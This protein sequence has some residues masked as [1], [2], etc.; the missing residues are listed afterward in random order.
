MSDQPLALVNADHQTALSRP[1]TDNPHWGLIGGVCIWLL[2]FSLPQVVPVPYL[3]IARS[4]GKVVIP[5]PDDLSTGNLDGRFI[6][7]S[8]VSTLIIHIIMLAACWAVVTHFG[9]LPF[10]ATLGWHWGGMPIWMRVLLVVGVMGTVIII[11]NFLPRVLPDTQITPFAHILKSSQI[12]KY[13]VAGVAVLTAPFVEELIY[14]GMFYAGLR[15]R[16]PESVSILVVTLVF[17][18]VHIQ[19]Y[20][21]AWSALIGLTTLSFFMT[22]IRAKTKSLLPC[23]VIHQI[24]NTIGGLGIL[25]GFE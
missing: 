9:R 24:N 21:G 12:A 19:Q 6:I 22:V 8:L 5:T 3:L 11:Q 1:D 23:V 20:W 18:I 16:L 13:L 17:A 7:I 25:L 2:S 4:A 15:S 10:F 14:R